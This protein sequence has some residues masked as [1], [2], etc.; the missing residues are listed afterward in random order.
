MTNDQGI[1]WKI[2]PG[3]LQARF[4]P[5]GGKPFRVSLQVR[6]WDTASKQEAAGAA[7][8]ALRYEAELRSGMLPEELKERMDARGIILLPPFQEL[9]A[10]SCTCNF[11]QPCSHARSVWTHFYEYISH[12]GILDAYRLRGLPEEELWPLVRAK[13][14]EAAAAVNA[15]A[16]RSSTASPNPV[17]YEPAADM[18]EAKEVTSMLKEYGD[19]PFWNRPQA[20]YEV[21]DLVYE[22]AAE[23]AA[24]TLSEKGGRS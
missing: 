6:E 8:E 12:R 7:A 3:K 9:A 16:G 11:T 19:P 5:N 4:S 14:A 24:Q 18:E 17:S 15:G 23:A 21:L 10:S 2:I 22:S 13:R 20:L 1:E